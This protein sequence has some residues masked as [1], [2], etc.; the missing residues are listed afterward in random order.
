MIM[1]VTPVSQPDQ[2]VV[3]IIVLVMVVGA[4][5]WIVQTA[6]QRLLNRFDKLQEDVDALEAEHQGAYSVFATKG[7]CERLEQRIIRG[8]DRCLAARHSAP[9]N[10]A[11]RPQ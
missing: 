8:E 2:L 9:A 11:H 7:D 1:P 5:T 3:L 6:V 4:L 10:D